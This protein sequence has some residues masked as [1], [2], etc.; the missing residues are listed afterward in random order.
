MTTWLLSVAGIVIIGAL[1]EVLLSD[2]SMSKFI[3][4][5]FGFFVLLVIVQP[6]LAMIKSGTAAVSGGVELN[7]GLLQ[8][9]NKQSAAAFEK[10]TVQA[11]EAAGFAGVIVTIDYDK[12][13]MNFKINRVFVNAYGIDIGKEKDVRRIVCAVCNIKDSE[14]F[15]V[16]GV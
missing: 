5:V 3:R 13:A 12:A 2:S 14:V 9:I 4:G 7:A 10:N 1:I 11:L 6:L 16:G 15:Y 8:T